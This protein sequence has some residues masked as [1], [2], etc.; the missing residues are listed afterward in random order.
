MGK[1]IG[2]LLLLAALAAAPHSQAATPNLA[3][4]TT[5]NDYAEE[6]DDESP[7]ETL[8]QVGDYFASWDA[9]DRP[10]IRYS[11]P[12]REWAKTRSAQDTAWQGVLR[13]YQ[14]FLT[15][16]MT[17]EWWALPVDIIQ[18]YRDKPWEVQGDGRTRLFV[19]ADPY[20]PPTEKGDIEFPLN[21]FLVMKTPHGSEIKHV[22]DGFYSADRENPAT[23]ELREENG[24]QLAVVTARSARECIRNT[25]L[26]EPAQNRITQQ[27]DSDDC[28]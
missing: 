7:E 24:R 25:F 21:F 6:P 15:E 18:E 23:L 2:I 22:V 8:A 17:D 5:M 12:P 4:D 9:F 3:S 28:R 13:E 19:V 14:M 26:L 16:A 10:E 11:M 1:Q 27:G 20:L